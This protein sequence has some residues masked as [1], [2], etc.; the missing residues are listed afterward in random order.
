MLKRF[1][2]I[3]LAL[4]ITLCSQTKGYL[5]LDVGN[6][7]YF[8]SNVWAPSVIRV[9]ADTTIGGKVYKSIYQRAMVDYLD[10]MYLRQ[11]SNKVYL[12]YGGLGTEFVLYDFASAAGDTFAWGPSWISHVCEENKLVLYA[13]GTRRQWSF[14]AGSSCM[15]CSRYETIVDSIGWRDCTGANY[16]STLTRAV[17]RG[18]EIVT[19]LYDTHEFE[20][21]TFEVALYPN[22][23]NSETILEYSVPQAGIVQ[24]SL[25]N[26]LGQ[27]VR[28]YSAQAPSGG[29]FTLSISANGLASGLYFCRVAYGDLVVVRKALLLK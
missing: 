18:R 23:F 26:V 12:Y 15:D 11:D 25:V 21:R 6:A 16:S 2:F 19:G 17:I 14:T 3:A 9:I 29:R 22:P 5:P 8:D 13:G 24:I 10:T 7:W 28:A 27:S 1:I 4:P 20:P